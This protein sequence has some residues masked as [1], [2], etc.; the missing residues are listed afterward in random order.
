MPISDEK[1][2]FLS[3][4]LYKIL[5]EVGSFIPSII[6][7]VVVFPAPLGPSKPKQEPLGIEKEISSTAFKERNDFFKVP[8]TESTERPPTPYS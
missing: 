6:S 4:P 7:I 8:A 1:L 2:L 5:P 3:L